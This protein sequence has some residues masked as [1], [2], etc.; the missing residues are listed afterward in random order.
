MS[1]LYEK[2]LRKLELDQVLQLLK[3]CSGSEVYLPILLTVS[4]G[5]RRGETLAL[6]WQDIDLDQKV[7]SIRHSALCKSQDIPYSLLI[8]LP[9]S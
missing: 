1:E 6:R 7:V 8:I 4:L 5:L 2:S 3:A 9:P